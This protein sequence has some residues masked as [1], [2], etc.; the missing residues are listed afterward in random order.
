M[1][2]SDIISVADR[3]PG[4]ISALAASIKSLGLLQPILLRAADGKGKYEVVDGRRR[5]E[6]LRSLGV[7]ELSP[8]QYT[9]AGAGDPALMAH[10]A[11]TERKDLSASE[12]VTQLAR[13]AETRSVEALARMMGRTPGWIAR[14]LKIS[15]LIP[16]WLK[17]LDDPELAGTWTLEKLAL[18]ARQ[19]EAV[20]KRL[21]WLKNRPWSVKSLEKQIAEQNLDLRS[22]VFDTA[23]CAG[24][25]ENSAFSELLFDDLAGPGRCLKTA[26]FKKK[27][28][29]AVDKVR[30]ERKLIPIRGDGEDYG[31]PDY[32]YAEKVKAEWDTFFQTVRNPKKGEE[33]NAIIVSGHNMGALKVAVPYAER[34]IPTAKPDDEPK[35]RTVKD[36]ELDLKRKRMKKA[37]ELLR[38]NFSQKEFTAKFIG[39]MS[40][41]EIPGHFLMCLSHWGYK[42]DCPYRWGVKVPDGAAVE[43]E[44]FLAT[45]FYPQLAQVVAE[46][47]KN[48]TGKTLDSINPLA[49]PSLCDLFK[50][51]WKG[52]FWEPAMAAIP[53]P[54]SLI[55]ARKKQKAAGKKKKED[56]EK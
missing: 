28:V 36:R 50:L 34:Q 41:E 42:G 40:D 43:L 55:E 22:A 15:Q 3:D 35:E 8:D 47:L 48:E 4:D 9:V 52:D 19:P 39:R 27:A 16:E 11:N 7:A 31:G 1:N 2:I 51:D 53:E 24:C 20:Q 37:L 13:L 5:L 29:A 56:P 21:G 49:G 25:P 17:V 45:E 18:I 38:E 32:L 10:V 26:C 46:D 44:E 33:P 12:E 23:C 54:K 30:K 6:A 14:R